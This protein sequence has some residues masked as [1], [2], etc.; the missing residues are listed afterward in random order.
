MQFWGIQPSYGSSTALQ[1]W[2]VQPSYGSA[3][4]MQSGT[5]QPVG[6]STPMHRQPG[7]GVL[8]SSVHTCSIQPSGRPAV[9]HRQP[10]FTKH[11]SK[12]WAIYIPMIIKVFECFPF[13]NL[14][15]MNLKKAVF[16]L[17]N[18]KL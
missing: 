4:A 10:A 15:L 11:R 13:I 18:E 3:T 1:F 6:L 5:I 7:Y 17:F 8:A 9:V 12:I 2:G 14:L 16:I